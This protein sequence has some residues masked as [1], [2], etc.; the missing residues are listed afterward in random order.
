MKFHLN[1]SI[2]KGLKCKSAAFAK[3]FGFHCF[4]VWKKKFLRPSNDKI[5]AIVFEIK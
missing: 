2:K 4:R 1:L 5:G 3:A